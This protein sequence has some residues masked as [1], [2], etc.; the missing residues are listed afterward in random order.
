MNE[1]EI[2]RDKGFFL[3]RMGLALT[4]WTEKWI[5]DAFNIALILT[6]IAFIGALIWGGVGPLKAIQGWGKGF[7]ILLKLAMQFTLTICFAYSVAVS[8]PAARLLNALGRVPNPE[9]PWQAIL[10]MAVFSLATGLVN[11]ALTIIISALLVPYILKNNPKVD[12]RVLAATAYLGLGAIWHSGLSGSAPLIAA[13]PDNF[14]IK[15]KI[16][17]DV[18]SPART[19]FSSW[20]LIMCL[21]A[22]VFLTI[23]AV[24]LTPS[25]ER[26]H[27]L[28]ADKL[29]EIILF[30]FPER[31]DRLTPGQM[32]SWWYGWNLI[33]AAF[34]IIFMIWHFHSA[35]LKAWTIDTYNMTFLILGVLLHRT[36]ISFIKSVREAVERA[37]GVIIQFP[38]YGG[39]FGIMR[40]TELGGFLTNVFISTTTQSTF[41]VMTYWWTAF[42]NYFVPSGGSQFVIQ[43][44]WMIEAGRAHGVSDAAITLIFGWGDQATNLIQPF[45][46]LPLLGILKLDFRQIMGYTIVMCLLIMLLMSLLIFI[47]NPIGL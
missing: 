13:T 16:I 28:P 11:W 14:L 25:K 9:K 27:L 15:S 36:P 40:Y 3:Q 20:N 10:L 18:I 29:D 21:V 1:Q 46:C 30:K 41:L 34:G 8:K 31:P 33:I 5:P 4:A 38:F 47:T 6:G 45:W 12:F 7:W 19:I 2:P 22:V 23:V 32:I 39:I 24:L 43:A 26:A 35:G 37:W 42:L 44:P 17:S